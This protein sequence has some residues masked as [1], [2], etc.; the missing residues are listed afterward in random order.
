VPRLFAALFVLIALLFAATAVGQTAGSIAVLQPDDE[1]MRAISLSL[2]PWGVDAIE[3]DEPP[4]QPLQPEAVQVASRL[5]TEL[6]VQAIVWISPAERGSLL[7]V[8]DARAGEITTR[9]VGETP[10]FD[11]AAAA[12]VALSVKTVLRSSVVAPPAERF[13]A[14]PPPSL[15]VEAPRVE[16][17]RE[18][19]VLALEI[20]AGA[21]FIAD[22]QVEAELEIAAVA[23]IAAARRL[24]LSLEL[25]FGPGLRIEDELYRGHYREIVLGGKARFRFVH[26]PGV[27]ADMALGG[28]LHFARLQGEVVESSLERSVTRLNPSLDAELSASIPIGSAAYVGASAEVGYLPAYQRYLVEGTPVFSPWPVTFGFGGH[29]G[30]ELF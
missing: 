24:G 16:A 18:E 12:A 11:S 7:W 26:E 28:A 8:F 17:P 20:G 23:W 9:L 4:P 29:F 13:G 2:S 15:P 6:G 25:S 1:L 5:A 30:I 10:P 14:Q 21:S 19:H 3:S 22:D 27:S